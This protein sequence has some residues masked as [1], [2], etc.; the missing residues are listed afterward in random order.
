M[1]FAGNLLQGVMGKARG[2]LFARCGLLGSV[3]WLLSSPVAAQ[4]QGYGIAT[5]GGAGGSVCTVTTSAESG[6]GSFDSC[7]A[8]G[9]NQTIQFAVAVA[10][11]RAI[12]R[13]RSNTTIDGCANGQNGVTLQQPADTDRTVSLEGPMSNVILR[14]LRF[15]NQDGGKRPGFNIEQDLVGVDG[16]GGLVSRVV[17]DRCTFVGATDGALDLT[18]NVQDVTV[19][20]SLFYGTPLTQL[21]KYDTRQ[22]ISIHHNVYTRNG[23]RNP[24]IKG[25]MRDIDFVSNVVHDSTITSDG[26][27]NTYSPYGTRL[28]NGGASSDSPGNVMGNFVANAWIGQNARLSIDTD[29]GASA[30]GI[31]LSG[32]YCN[33]GS[34]PASPASSPRAVPAAN[35][36]SVTIPTSMRTQMLPTVGSPNRTATDQARLDA[37]AA[38]LPATCTPVVVRQI[39]AADNMVV[40]GDTGASS[41]VFT[42]TL[43]GASSCPVTVSYSTAGV[44]AAP[45]VDYDAV[46]GII[47]FPVGTTSQNVLV[48]VRGD[49]VFEGDETLVLNLTAPFGATIADP[50]ATGTIVNDDAPGFSIDDVDVVEPPA[51]TTTA[52]FTVTLSPTSGSAT[53]VSYATANGTAAAPGDYAAKSGTLSFAAGVSSQPVSVVVNGDGVKEGVETFLVNLSNP[54]G[55]PAIG[56][57]QATGRIFDTGAFVSVPPC[58]VVDT[59]G[60]APIGGPALAANASRS[61]SLGTLCGIPAQARAVALNLTITGATSPGDLRVFPTGVS[62]PLASAINY[63]VGQTRANNLIV[64]LSSGQ[65]TVR[66]DQAA[67]VVHMILDVAGYFP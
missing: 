52:S 1:V 45:G 55:G 34:C 11:V 49:R 44:T 10:K 38:A 63:S 59:R 62:L 54:T 53:S 31:Y 61:F 43:S 67:G 13:V 16:T 56:G 47:S 27:G 48:P 20:R 41:L 24:Q 17:V 33:P 14:C 46:T 65:I 22:R 64:S 50:Q 32:N 36:V 21:I 40:E 18:G 9:G 26:V 8:R 29:T 2:S 60:G 51:G 15:E 6:N 25:D 28:W 23:E 66:C 12:A 58:R 19:Q 4:I 7:V 35:V 30:A 37:V 42:V 57:G 3:C 5:T 39:S